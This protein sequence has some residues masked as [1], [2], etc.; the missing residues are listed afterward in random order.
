M[1]VYKVSLIGPTGVGK[2]SIQM[3]V[4]ENKFIEQ[5]KSTVGVTFARKEKK[6]GDKTITMQIWDFG[7]QLRFQVISDI[8]VKGSHAVLL[9]FDVTRPR[10]LS[11]LTTRWL[12]LVQENITP[13]TI[14]FL[15][16]NKIDLP[17]KVEQ[18][19]IDDVINKYGFKYFETSAK[20]GQG[21]ENVFDELATR[22]SVIEPTKTY[23]IKI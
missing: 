23:H 12:K 22:L 20:T 18:K 21:L 14:L 17:K 13:S 4:A 2:T 6:V 19:E 5:I 9:I 3:K 1:G 11:E 16:G 8:L 10:T 15:V 7:G